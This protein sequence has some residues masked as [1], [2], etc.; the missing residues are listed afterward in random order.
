[1]TYRFFSSGLLRS[2]TGTLDPA[3][4]NDHAESFFAAC[5]ATI[6]HGGNLAYYAQEADYVQMPPFESVRDAE[7][8]YSTLA[9][10]MTSLDEAPFAAGARL[11]GQAVG[12]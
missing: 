1:M 3:A 9:H 10:E 12:R 7:S 11:R 8:Y 5:R 4:R 6:C 2:L